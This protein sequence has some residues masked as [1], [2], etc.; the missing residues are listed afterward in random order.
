MMR[1]TALWLTFKSNSRTSRSAP[2]PLRFL[3]LTICPSNPAE[4]LCGQRLGARDFSVSEEGLPGIARRIHLRTD[5]VARTAELARRHLDS[6]FSGM[7]HDLLV[8]PMTICAHMIQ[9]KIMAM[10]P[11]KMSSALHRSAFGCGGPRCPS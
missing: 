2:K 8:K 11:R 7:A 5:G 9:L 6:M 10:H 1:A 3:N 4:V